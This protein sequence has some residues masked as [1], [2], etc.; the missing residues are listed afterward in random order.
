MRR[1]GAV[2]A[3]ACMCVCGGEASYPLWDGRQSV[4]EYAELTGLDISRVIDL[5]N[6]VTIEFRLV[7][8]G[9]YIMGVEEP[10]Q[11]WVWGSITGLF[12]VI[13]VVMVAFVIIRSIRRHRFQYSLRWL[14]GVVLVIA[15]G[16]YAFIKWYKAD[17]AQGTWAPPFSPAHEVTINRPFYMSKCEIT[18][19]Q[20]E[21]IMNDNPSNNIGD[22]LPVDLVSWC[23][24]REYC[25]IL[26]EK[27]GVK[28]RLPSESEWEY[29]CRAGTR[30]LYY[31]GET[32][33][34]LALIAWYDENSK[35]KTHS[36]GQKKAN[37][38][39]LHD[40]L[41]N[42]AEICED[43]W[44]YD[45]KMAPSNEHPWVENARLGD[46]V[47]RGGSF[48]ESAID[49]QCAARHGGLVNWRGETRKVRFIGN[50]GFRIVMELK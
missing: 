33:S 29:A 47:V 7:P 38:F 49:C 37:A 17:I 34:D 25:R 11:P 30:S 43:D 45:Y 14:V 24:A 50:Q 3:F 6:G 32:E 36:V 27:S 22:K 41:G 4:S 9:K 2:I 12:A 31:N 28:V 15:G 10:D 21:K 39:G 16:E 19:G 23:D 13:I 8:A 42:V 5:G 48:S 46:I 26:T 44:H 20:Y 35:Y 40:M 18:Q 1:T